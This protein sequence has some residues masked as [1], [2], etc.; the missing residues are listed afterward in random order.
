MCCLFTL[1]P[2][3][4]LIAA[5]I[6]PQITKADDDVQ[7]LDDF[8]KLQND[9]GGYRNGF[10][11]SPSISVCRRV[12]HENS[13]GHCFRILAE[14]AEAGYC[15][16][17]IHLHNF[18]DAQPEFVDASSWKYLTFRF[19]TDSPLTGVNVRVADE[20]WIH[21]EDAV[22]IGP[23]SRWAEDGVSENW[24]EVVIPLAD[25]QRI[26]LKRLGALSFEFQSPG[27]FTLW[28]DDLC[29]KQTAEAAT[30]EPSALAAPAVHTLPHR[31]MWVWTTAAIIGDSRETDRLLEACRAERI[32]HLWMQLPYKVESI[33][34]VSAR[35]T[36][37]RIQS[38]DHLRAFIR[39]AHNQKIKIHALDGSPEFAIQSGHSIPL[40]V[41]DAVAEFNSISKPEE[42]FD[43]VHFDNEP[44]L[45]LGWGN[46][47][48]REE[49]LH[50]LL[51]LNLE[52][53]HKAREA[54]LTFGVDVPF[55][56]NAHDAESGEAAGA[57]TFHGSRKAA[58]FHCIDHLDNVGIMNYRD[59]ADGA[60]GMLAHGL[61]ILK[62]GDKTAHA[63]V[64]M[65]VETFRYEP[66]PVWFSLGLP[67]SEFAAA[68]TDRARDLA[69]LSRLHGLR[70]YRLHAAGQVHVGV[71]LPPPDATS[72]R[73]QHTEAAIRILA[74]E[75]GHYSG[76]ASDQQLLATTREEVERSTEWTNWL[77]RP[78]QDSAAGVSFSGFVTTRLMPSKVTF[79][80]DSIASFIEETGF[81]EQTFGRYRS[82]GG[83]AIHSWESYRGKRSNQGNVLPRE[84]R[85]GR[86]SI[87]HR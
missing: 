9:V 70:L 24:R 78:V 53:Q 3:A 2:C 86:L 13:P 40:A 51:T 48:L 49:I 72:E 84:S 47:G 42:R 36:S 65:G 16:A 8:E 82:Y 77:R 12:R 80:D 57:V 56:W 52:C 64:F 79:A 43:G 17:W 45:L 22:T 4:A 41:V 37:V 26:D 11:K 27:N 35:P 19:K 21:K 30:P 39:K 15:G 25:V 20:K 67:E 87:R 28:I 6:V 61:D 63:S 44:Y 29:L 1:L 23:L 75:F 38:V 71:E 81:A 62:Y 46:A 5:T 69:G 14:R 34:S 18:R 10:S 33:G 73:I 55:W 76:G 59:Q 85:I 60:D 74:R 58:T 66:Q 83:L 54:G 32:A 50:D 68:L 31:A 7:V